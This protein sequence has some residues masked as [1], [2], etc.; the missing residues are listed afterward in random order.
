MVVMS[1][2]QEKLLLFLAIKDGGEAILL[3]IANR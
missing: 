2:K 1:M 3:L